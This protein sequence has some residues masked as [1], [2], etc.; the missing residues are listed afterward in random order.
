[1]AG[2][3]AY[4]CGCSRR[5][6]GEDFE[7][8][9]AFRVQDQVCCSECVY[10]L[11]ADLS[12]EEQEA[13]LN[14]PRKT[15]ATRV[16]A[17][18]TG[19]TSTNVK[20][21]SGG[22]QARRATGSV[23]KADAPQSKTG[24]VTKMRSTGAIP[25]TGSTE[26]VPAATGTRSIQR[27][28]TTR[29]VPKAPPP[30][31]AEGEE[32]DEG[33][34][35]DNKKK[36]LLFGGIGAGVLVIG[37]VVAIL[38][39]SGGSPPPVAVAPA[40]SPVAPKAPVKPP[41]TEEAAKEAM[42]EALK[43]Q[44]DA[45]RLGEYYTKLQE[46]AS[47]GE[48]TRFADE[49]K[50]LLTRARKTFDE[51]LAKMDE[52]NQPLRQQ[53]LL[54]DLLAAWEKEKARV[55]GTELQDGPD[56]RISNLRDFIDGKFKTY[57]AAALDHRRRGNEDAVREQVAK[58]AKWNLKE[59]SDELEKSLAAVKAG[60]AAPTTANPADPSTPEPPKAVPLSP[61]MQKYVP[62]WQ[63]AI[64]KAFV[65]DFEGAVADLGRTAR[66]ID[67]DEV[68]KESSQ[69]QEALRQAAALVE[70]A[71][72]LIPTLVPRFQ[73]VT[74]EYLHR[75]GEFRKITGK[76]I[77]VFAQ[78]IELNT[79]DKEKP[80]VFVEIADLSAGTLAEYLL[81]KSEKKDADAKTCALLCLIE[82]NVEGAKKH[83]GRA[84]SKIAERYWSFA[85][86]AREKAPR[87][88][89]REF[90]ARDL[91]HG[92]EVD[93]R[94]VKNWGPAIDKYKT[95]K[96]DYASSRIV[97]DNQAVIVSRSDVGREY[98]FFPAP[99]GIGFSL[100]TGPG[101]T[102]K[103]GK[104]PKLDPA[105]I[106][107]AWI[108][109]EDIDFSLARDNFVEAEFYAL[110]GTSYR[111]WAYIGAC[112]QETFAFFYQTTE[113][114]FKD[115]GKEKAVDPGGR[116]AAP[117]LD[118]PP[119]LKKDHADH[120]PRNVKE[121]PKEPARWEWIQIP[122]PRT[123]AGAGPKSVRIITDQS[124]F[125]V[126]YVLIVPESRRVVPSEAQTKDLAK[127]AA[128]GGAK[129]AGAKEPAEWFVAGPFDGA[130]RDAHEPE[131]GIDLAKEMKGK[132]GAGVKW[133]AATATLRPVA[134]GKAAVFDLD[135]T[136]PQKDGST[137]YLLIHV[138]AT[139]P[140]EARLLL[141]HDDGL[142]VWVNGSAVYT[143]NAAKKVD[144]VSVNIKLEDGWNRLL[145]KVSNT[146]DSWM[147]AARVT[148]PDRRPIEELEYHTHGDALK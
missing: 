34:S 86:E 104:H 7:Q 140:T 60:D 92:A 12:A 27:Q 36:L 132:G 61:A 18:R 88:N 76:V 40:P 126:G 29:S 122:I 119:N 5:L 41:T 35:P 102:F 13:I 107:L 64:G 33:A 67:E 26:K 129:V 91:F 120:K 59:Y 117:N 131:S 123:Y 108:T 65:R 17:A 93:W 98:T 111:C 105:K 3:T 115:K 130:L 48:G 69:D 58:I 139:G 38:L 62:K 137:A 21:V 90:E 30:P 63:E 28:T 97:R 68:K 80:R 72:G 56:Q 10:D 50:A 46:V 74:L 31:P 19:S 142:K 51:R 82:G 85:K 144:D 23:P 9:S 147:V 101:S 14:P 49:A 136:F 133:K 121:H 100:S 16:T 24:S 20:T 15:T 1:M 135:K 25:K 148:D 43:L 45:D 70:R 87:G 81:P 37:V 127:E 11:I 84:A 71:K 42:L 103:L 55:D 141:G 78:R 145:F 109:K 2:E 128:G 53:E 95:L 32:G 75:P 96:S 106:E 89:T 47:K 4:C 57:K 39:L 22:T 66:D 83:G 94:E 124:G 146:K 54:G 125:G 77:K 99:S 118:M 112:C 113:G 134:G 44:N 6:R 110:P 8:R 73:D 138:K 116:F 79:D 52:D 114:I 143:G